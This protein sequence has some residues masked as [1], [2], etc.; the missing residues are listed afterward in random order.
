[1]RCRISECDGKIYI[2]KNVKIVLTIQKLIKI[3]SPPIYIGIYE[4]YD[5]NN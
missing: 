1:M 2:K 4:K 3:Q 5:K